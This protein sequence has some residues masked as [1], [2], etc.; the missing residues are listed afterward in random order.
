MIALTLGNLVHHEQFTPAMLA[1]SAIVITGLVI[2]M[3]GPAH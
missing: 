3:R 1:G 2:G